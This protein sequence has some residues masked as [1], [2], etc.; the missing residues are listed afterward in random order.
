MT[1]NVHIFLEKLFRFEKDV[2]FLHVK[3]LNAVCVKNQMPAAMSL[4][5]RDADIQ[6]I[7]RVTS[8]MCLEHSKRKHGKDNRYRQHSEGKARQEGTLGARNSCQMAEEDYSRRR[9]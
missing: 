7:Q 8:D 1:K 6:D 3:S 5:L 2:L 9:G 4:S